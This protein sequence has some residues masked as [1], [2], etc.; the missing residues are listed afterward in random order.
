MCDCEGM[1]EGHTA[2]LFE[3]ITE[4]EALSDSPYI[5]MEEAYRSGMFKAFSKI[6]PVQSSSEL[7][8]KKEK[9]IKF[10]RY[11]PIKD[12]ITDWEDNI[13]VY[14]TGGEN[15]KEMVRSPKCETAAPLGTG[16]TQWGV[17]PCHLSRST[18]SEGEATK[19]DLEKSEGSHGNGPSFPEG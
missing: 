9:I 7:F 16:R 3:E 13:K 12:Q 4:R 14:G 17:L 19:E 2:D 8:G 1:W 6:K 15:E 18:Y 10:R 5:M 11:A